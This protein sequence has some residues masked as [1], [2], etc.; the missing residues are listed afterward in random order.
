MKFTAFH[1]SLAAAALALATAAAAPAAK[2][3]AERVGI[4]P[5]G[6]NIMFVFANAV[7]GQEAE[8]NTWYNTHMQA[9]MK[10]PGFVRCQRFEM[11]PRKGKA[12]PAFRYVILYE[13]NGDPDTV[14]AALGPAV[15][16]G[17]LQ[18]PDPRYVL[19]TEGSVYKAIQPGFLATNK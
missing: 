13:F 3:A 15:K 9:I 1:R 5:E 11:Q 7:P 16:E 14:I 6:T 10:L 18:A 12:D 17:R 2:P 4:V 8:F 19:K